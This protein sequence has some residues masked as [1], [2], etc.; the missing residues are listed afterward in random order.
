MVRIKETMTVGPKGQVVIPAH[1]RRALSIAPGTAVAVEL[2]EGKIV[3]EKERG[4]EIIAKFRELARKVNLKEPV[5]ADE[6]YEEMMED[7]WKKLLT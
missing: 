4:E 5:D 1:L 3:I 6:A 7:R 2:E